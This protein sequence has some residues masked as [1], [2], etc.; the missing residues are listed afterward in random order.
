MERKKL[1]CSYDAYSVVYDLQTN[2]FSISASGKPVLQNAV[3]TLN[4]HTDGQV[5]SLDCYK[6]AESAQRFNSTSY[7]VSIQFSEADGL[8]AVTADFEADRN[9]VSLRFSQ[10]D[11]YDWHIDGDLY[12]GGNMAKNTFAMSNAPIH[13]QVRSAMGPATS[14]R[15]NML[16]DRK[17]DKAFSID[18]EQVRLSF[19]WSSLC[20][21][22]SLSS[23]DAQTKFYFSV[24]QDVLAQQYD[25]HFSPINKNNTFPKPPAGWM[26]WYAV[27]FNTS[28]ESVLRNVRFQEEHLKRYGANAVWID[29]E[30]YHQDMSGLRDDGVD[31]FHPDPKKYPHG[32]KFI[33]DEIKKSGFTPALWVGFTNEPALNEYFK[34]YPELLLTEK[35]TWCGTYFYDISN[36]I[37]LNDFLPKAL[38]QVEQWG[39]EAVKF[40]TLPN[41]I[42]YHEEFHDNMYDP[43]LTTKEAFRNAMRRAREL[44]GK[45]VYIMSCASC[46]DPHFLWAADIF[47]GGRVGGDIFAWKAFLWEGVGK[48]LRFYPLHNVVLYADPDNVVMR[49][50]F[51]TSEQAFSRLA[52]ISLMGLPMTFGD[53]FVVLPEERIRWIQKCLPVM[54]I[55]PMDLQV[56]ELPDGTQEERMTGQRIADFPEEKLLIN[57]AVEQPFQRYN[58][59]DVFNTSDA[60]QQM[61]ISPQQDLNLELGEYL[62]FDFLHQQFLGCV[63]ESITLDLNPCESRI[64]RV[65][66]KLEH[67][68][69]L[70]TSRHISQGAVEIEQ[71]AWSCSDHTL[72]ITCQTVPGDPY[73]ITLF[74]PE[75]YTPCT[76]SLQLIER[77]AAWSG[78]VYRFQIPGEADG[79]FSTTLSFT[80]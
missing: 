43:S 34:K 13:W 30:W 71:A 45:D 26:T 76:D 56:L 6:N 22:C 29:W 74:V 63:T 24:K 78:A 47:D 18:G 55:H 27:K 25:I 14:T 68:Q 46:D 8:D 60:P 31:T 52:F 49:D 23:A 39:Y 21:R 57:L 62:V 9:G 54:D 51:N 40:D 50:E 28:E 72:S 17:T 20:Y 69:I 79:H 1:Y 75:D 59:V 15:D 77:A 7:G 73:D 66:K 35:K 37:Y 36:P 10:I 41:T 2:Q 19:D 38:A 64:L 80:K 5:F 33:S 44:I 58:V 4:R 11:G 70:G 48:I 65:Q 53:D 32:L 61:Q 42:Y 16:Y 12:W 3:I 67:P